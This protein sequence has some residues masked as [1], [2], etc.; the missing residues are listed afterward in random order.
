MQLT[1]P[2]STTF[3]LSLIL[4]IF[5]VAL[6]YIPGLAGHIPLDKFY[7]AVIAYLIL[8]VGNLVRGV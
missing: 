1:P 7:I 6:P 4:A 8:L 5:A 2:T 3:F